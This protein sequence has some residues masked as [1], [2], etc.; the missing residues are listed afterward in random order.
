MAEKVTNYQCPACTGPLRFDEEKGKL[1]CDYCGSE[2]DV[3]EIE[4]YYRKKD[5]EAAA[6][7]EKEKNFENKWNMS[8]GE[9][10]W[11]IKEHLH[12]YNCPSCGAELLCDE[13]TVA[14]SCPYCN[15]PTIVPG[16]VSGMLKPDY[17]IPFKID[18][19]A[20]VKALSDHYKGKRLLPKEFTKDNHIEEVKGIYVPFWLFNGS[21]KADATYHATRSFT[22]RQGNYE[23]VTT[24]HYNVHRAGSFAFEKIPVDASSKM[25]DD[26]MDSMEPYDYKELKEFST[27]YLPGFLA[28]KYDVS[29]TDSVKRA[30]RRIEATALDCLKNTVT[31]YLTCTTTGKNVEIERGKVQYALLP[32]WVLCTKFNG[33]DYLFTMNGQT[34]KLV[35]D[36]PISKG[37]LLAYFFG[38]SIPI[39]I[40]VAIVMMFM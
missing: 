35:G 36:L 37:R 2:Y 32:V 24:E 9:S 7:L 14:T 16:K 34:G 27:A 12:S 19:S 30:E 13:T 17:V 5:E 21:A 25:P 33:K 29:V 1:L 28:D 31:G 15:N 20:A 40:V 23:V 11:G 22:T 3:K 8:E 38:I 39:A 18:K 4:Q 26:Y 10:E 6:E